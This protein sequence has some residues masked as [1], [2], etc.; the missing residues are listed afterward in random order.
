MATEVQPRT[1]SVT[2]HESFVELQIERARRRIR[3]LD[4]AALGLV[5]LLVSMAYGLGMTFLDRWL[6]LAPAIRLAGFVA[7]AVTAVLFVAIA[8]FRMF[9]RRI[10]PYYAARQIE[11]TLPDAKNSVVNWLDLRDANLVPAIR[12]ALGQRAARDLKQADL[13]RAI[14]ARRTVWLSGAVLALALVALVLYVLGGGQF[15]SLLERAFA[16]F[17]EVAIATRTTLTILQPEGGDAIVP[18]GRPVRF[19]VRVEGRVPRVNQPDSLKLHYRYNP[20]DPCVEQG[21]DLDVDNE[22][23]TTVLADQVQNGFW[24]KISGGD[25]STPEYQVRVMSLPQATRFDVKYHYRPYRNRPDQLV[26][27]PNENAVYPH[28]KAHRG[29]EVTLTARA[30][31]A[32][33]SGSLEMN[34]GGIRKEFPGE[35]LAGDPEALRFQFTLEHSGT[36]ALHFVAKEGESNTDRTPHRIDVLPDRSPVVTLREP[37]KDVE[38]PANGT[39]QLKGWAE[40]DFGLK[41]MTLRLRVDKGPVLEAKPYRAGKSFRLDNGDYPD[42]LDYQ[43]FV[44]LEQVKNAKGVQVPLTP[45]MQV[46]Y[47]LEATDNCDYPD[48]NGNVGRSKEFTVKIVPAT[49]NKKEQQEKRQQAQKDQQR[50]EQQQD[51]QLDHQNEKSSEKEAQQGDSGDGQKGSSRQG[52]A[53]KRQK[54]F[55]KKAK[56]L[57]DALKDKAREDRSKGQAKGE[58]PSQ[59]KGASKEQ[60]TGK[61]DGQAGASKK[62]QATAKEQPG[63]QKD[64]GQGSQQGQQAEA[65]DAGSS[66]TGKAHP[67]SPDQPKD[68]GK[69]NAGSKNTGAKDDGAGAKGASKPKNEQASA[70]GQKEGTTG[71]GSPEA[72]AA[73]GESKDAGQTKSGQANAQAKD[74]GKQGRLQPKAAAKDD[75]KGNTGASTSGGGNTKEAPKNQA[76]QAKPDGGAGKSPDG[77]TK[78]EGPSQAEKGQTAQ[79]QAKGEQQS[80]K[81]TAKKEGSAGRDGAENA[82]VKK[83]GSSDGSPR[84]D[85]KQAQ[86]DQARDAG[87]AKDDREPADQR[88]AQGQQ[89]SNATM[90]DVAKLNEALKR[91][92]EEAADDLARI[93]KEATDP[94]VRKA[95]EEALKNAGRQAKASGQE[96]SPGPGKKSDGRADLSGTKSPGD[97]HTPNKAGSSGKEDSAKADGQKSETGKG[98]SGAGGKPEAGKEQSGQRKQPGGVPLAPGTGQFDDDP[99]KRPANDDFAGR[100]GMLQLEDLKSKV[101]PEL[102]KKLNWS[103]KD[104]QQFQ[105]QARQYEMSRKRQQQMAGMEKTRAGSSLLPSTGPRKVDSTGE[106]RSD[107]LSAGQALPPPEF[108]DAQRAFTSRPDPRKN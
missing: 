36:F 32:V 7:Y 103:D 86:P 84:A 48:K 75:G 14:S 68:N 99:A 35:L 94:Q 6:D 2:K 27:Y 76:A 20:A 38:L 25:T 44:A 56:Q 83:E 98:N 108:R 106:P 89:P 55:E 72:S 104:W 80:P 49:G 1:R 90:D 107:D 53:D 57:D 65:K 74:G 39:L 26:R 60:G 47:W 82:A 54:D 77:Q 24:Y 67:Q 102:L 100:G 93:N 66:Q 64:Q 4:A 52:Q 34:L 62:Q 79:G 87:V 91:G 33:R 17:K 16:P 63:K 70:K 92:K 23:T 46:K 9:S 71:Q 73:A 10:N 101:T 95:A 41:A 22:W 85:S 29:T 45:G 11:Q 28:V 30:N 3:A 50:H 21:L 105:A 81:G 5:F 96:Q 59:T 69:A 42:K 88:Q 51:K 58:Q 43:D 12:G 31:R 13:D 78:P 18:V 40:D 97:D 61:E 19:R 37:G 15:V 8:G